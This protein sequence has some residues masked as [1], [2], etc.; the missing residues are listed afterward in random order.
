MV[1]DG[2]SVDALGSGET[3]PPTAALLN[4]RDGGLPMSYATTNPYTGEVSATFPTATPEQIDTA[5]GRADAAFH[6]WRDVPV[7][8]RAALMGRAA[9][10]LRDEHRAFA[11][12]LT[13]EMG[14]L[15]GEAEAEV[16]LTAKIFQY[17]ARQGPQ[18]LAPRYL[19][20]EGYGD[21]DVALINEPVGVIYMVEPWNFPYYQLVR[22]AGPMV[23]AGNTVI[24]KHASSVPQAAAAFED[25]MRRAGAPDGVVTNLYASHDASE[26]ILADRRVQGAALT[27]SEKAG[28]SIGAIAGQNLK[29]STLELGGCDFFIVLEDAEV[30]KAAS[31]AVTGRH[32]NAGQVCSSAKRMIVMDAVY[33]QFLAAYRDGVSHLVPGDPMDP[34]TTL[35]PLHAAEAVD[36]L[37]QQVQAA[38]EEGI[39]V[40]AIGPEV[41]DQGA[42]F[43]PLLLTGIPTDSATADTEF[44]GPVTQLFR[45]ADVDDAVRIANSSTFGLGGSVFS[46][47]IARAQQI[48]RRLETGMVYINQP[49][50]VRADVPF[51][52]VKRS[53]YGREL[54]DLGLLEFVN[55]KVVAV[56][57][58]DGPFI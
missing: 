20:A 25:L 4:H 17:Y 29:K 34:D 49:T 58:I 51:G 35:A 12:I 44:F 30:D 55:Q 22:A 3:T 9:D 43:R 10:L 32:W 52:G 39:T 31:W 13:R 40:E 14:K 41:P 27:G 42:F 53:G 57:D 47:D 16:E 36:T 18:L 21:T 54:T 7:H 11:E 50:G 2:R 24:Y 15:I 23:T 38:R 26:Q 28:A 8:G 45:A 56:A 19:A 37:D 46:R 5:I 48:A 33:D 6:Q 1:A